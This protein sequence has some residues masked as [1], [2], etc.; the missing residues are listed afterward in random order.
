ML[1]NKKMKICNNEGINQWTF[2][3]ENFRCGLCPDNA[4]TAGRNVKNSIK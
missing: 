4:K 1:K 3:A 2:Q